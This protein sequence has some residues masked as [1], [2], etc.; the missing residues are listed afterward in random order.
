MTQSVEEFEVLNGFF[1]SVFTS[2]TSLKQFLAPEIR[3]RSAVRKTSLVE[4][5]QA[6]E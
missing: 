6:R 3:D 1:T 4:E 2:K 5:D